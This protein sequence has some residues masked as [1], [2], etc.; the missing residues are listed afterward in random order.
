MQELSPRGNEE[1]FQTKPPDAL[2]MDKQVK[3]LRCGDEGLSRLD[4]PAGL[5]FQTAQAG[6]AIRTARNL[7]R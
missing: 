3:S 5:G 6:P 4:T 1:G 2:D 7:A